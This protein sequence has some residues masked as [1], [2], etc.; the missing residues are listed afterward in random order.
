MIVKLTLLDT[1]R[2]LHPM[3]NS[4]VT[5]GYSATTPELGHPLLVWYAEDDESKYVRTSRV[6]H[7]IPD[8]NVRNGMRSWIVKTA[9][10]TYKVEELDVQVYHES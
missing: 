9:N 7:I 5:R 8:I 2:T 4:K 3:V 1:D 10:S 6:D